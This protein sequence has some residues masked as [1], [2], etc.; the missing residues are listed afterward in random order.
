MTL[1]KYLQRRLVLS[2]TNRRAGTYRDAG[3]CPEHV[4]GRYINHNP[5]K[6]DV[7][8]P[9]IKFVPSFF[10]GAPAVQAAKPLSTV[11]L[12]PGLSQVKHN[13]VHA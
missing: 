9:P 7:L 13:Y 3:I 12:P 4:I 1:D 5:T 6:G 2:T 10:F 8:Y 11:V